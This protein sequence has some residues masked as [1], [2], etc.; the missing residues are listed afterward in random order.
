MHFKY[1]F[2][3][4]IVDLLLQR[5][6]HNRRSRRLIMRFGQRD[7][8]LW[9]SGGSKCD[10]KMACTFNSSEGKS[11]RSPDFFTMIRNEIY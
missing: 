2:I 11:R 9:R 1:V 5:T 3:G 4:F 8:L 7:A 10:N 6:K